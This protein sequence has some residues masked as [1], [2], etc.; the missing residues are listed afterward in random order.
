MLR[1]FAVLLFICAVGCGRELPPQANRLDI[2]LNW[3]HDPTFAGEYLLLSEF[4]QD[5]AINEGGPNV[6]PVAE[7]LA[8]RS[9]FAVIGADIFLKA[10][11]ED[12]ASGRK[13][14][15]KA[16]FA[17]FQR[18]P[19][20]WVLHPSAAE[21]AGLTDD[22]RQN[23]NGADLNNWL[24]EKLASGQLRVGDKRG[25]ETTAIWLAWI[26]ARGSSTSIEVVP[27]GFDSSVV[28][29]APPLVFPV[30]LNEEPYRLAERIG[31]ELVIF[32]P[33][34]DGVQAYGNVVVAAS[35]FVAENEVAV[36]EFVDRM[37]RSWNSARADR[38]RAARLVAQYYEGVSSATLNQQ[39][40]R[41][42]EF[43]FFDGADA[44]SMDIAPEGK[45]EQTIEHLVKGGTLPNSFSLETA[46]EYIIR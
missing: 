22:Q 44:G 24:F 18:N 16:I 11:A 46:S 38:P 43:V 1:A 29:D 36:Q 33:S 12:L 30:Y 39:V 17:D 8:G 45:W 26:A 21:A 25:T 37:K 32:D 2:Q 9:E 35:S 42:V 27:V 6:F 5:Y 40:A 7:V 41:T 14:R 13:G 10:T 23:M 20:G 31:R 4:P 19:V 28:L 15:L 3:L 34:D